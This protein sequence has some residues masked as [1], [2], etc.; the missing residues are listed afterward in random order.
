MIFFNLEENGGSIPGERGVHTMT[1]GGAHCGHTGSVK[2]EVWQ[3]VISEFRFVRG[4]LVTT[5]GF[6]GL[7][8]PGNIGS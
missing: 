3:A 6:W 2:L 8:D 7:S 5:P 1:M 4:R